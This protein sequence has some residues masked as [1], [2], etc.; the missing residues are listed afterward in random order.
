MF[1]RPRSRFEIS[2]GPKKLYKGES[3]KS[4]MEEICCRRSKGVVA[5]VTQVRHNSAWGK[6]A[7]EGANGWLSGGRRWRRR[8]AWVAAVGL[9]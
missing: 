4:V 2:N 3:Y 8:R 7:R 6:R 5:R 9:Q 1:L